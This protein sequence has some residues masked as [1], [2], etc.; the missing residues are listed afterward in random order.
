M[1]GDYF[2]LSKWA[3]NLITSVLIRGRQREIAHREEE[4]AL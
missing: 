1:G 3:L 2:K 4:K